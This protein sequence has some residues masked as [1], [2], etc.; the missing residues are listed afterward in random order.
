[1]TVAW[2]RTLAPGQATGLLKRLYDQ[3]LQR[4]GKVF[5]ILRVQSLR[6]RVLQ[7]STRLYVELMQSSEGGLTRAQREMIATVVSR[8]NGC[9]Y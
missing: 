8:T 2:I 9:F 7:A 3:A 1:V 6:P 4:A 5:H